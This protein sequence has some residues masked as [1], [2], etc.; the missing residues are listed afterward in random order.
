MFPELQRYKTKR[1]GYKALNHAIRRQLFHWPVW[2]VLIACGLIW[3]ALLTETGLPQALGRYNR[4]LLFVVFAIWVLIGGIG[5]WYLVATLFQQRVRVALRKDLI[6][7]GAQV[8]LRCGYDLTGNV[9]GD[10]PECG[11]E[12]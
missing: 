1:E 9:S 8:C 10:C 4:T 7:Q 5:P 2:I 11:V 3:T 12:C 6:K